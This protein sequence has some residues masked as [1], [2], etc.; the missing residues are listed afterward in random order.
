MFAL[1]RT[2]NRHTAECDARAMLAYVDAHL[3]ADATRG[4]GWLP[5]SGLFGWVGGRGLPERFA[6]LVSLIHGAPHGHP[7]HLTR[8]T[9]WRCILRCESCFCLRRDRPAAAG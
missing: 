2:L 4:P 3:K 6:C 7:T 1:M 9:A 8:R 5:T